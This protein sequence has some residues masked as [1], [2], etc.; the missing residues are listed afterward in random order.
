[1]FYDGHV[2]F[3]LYNK[4][5]NAHQR[6]SLPHLLS[7]SIPL[8]VYIRNNSISFLVALMYLDHDVFCKY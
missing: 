7:L 1:M 8:I 3:R 4:A 5:D 2:N 6:A